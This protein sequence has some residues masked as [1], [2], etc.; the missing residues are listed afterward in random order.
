MLRAYVCARCAGVYGDPADDH[1]RCGGVVCRFRACT[2]RH[3]SSGRLRSVLL[4]PAA[5]RGPAPARHRSGRLV[6]RGRQSQ[7]RGRIRPG[8]APGGA[9]GDGP[10]VRLAGGPGPWCRIEASVQDLGV[11]SSRLV[12]NRRLDARSSCDPRLRSTVG[13]RGSSDAAGKRD[14]RRSTP[15]EPRRSEGGHCGRPRLRGARRSLHP[16][17][18]AR[19]RPRL[20]P[21]ERR[22]VPRPPGPRLFGRQPIRPRHRRG[23]RRRG[24]SDAAERL[25]LDLRPGRGRSHQAHRR[26]APVGGP[27]RSR[28]GARSP[29]VG[30]ADH[31]NSGA[32]RAAYLPDSAFC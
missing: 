11:R 17:R 31:P 9:L 13:L 23:P 2:E 12:G 18:A 5:R 24:R 16:R 29:P 1:L 30:A 14:G 26:L 4:G 8:R 3:A 20:P 21:R 19:P 22:N 27:G 10:P 32:A 28:R 6:R 7:S 25:P 15:A